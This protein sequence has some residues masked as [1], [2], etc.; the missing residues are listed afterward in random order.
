MS[1][2]TVHHEQGLWDRFTGHP[3]TTTAHSEDREGNHVEGTGSSRE[4]ATQNLEE[5]IRISNAN[6]DK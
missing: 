2:V 5:A 4:E 6:S 1:K 3:G